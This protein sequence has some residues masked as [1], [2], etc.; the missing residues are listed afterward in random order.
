[1]IARA[2]CRRIW[3]IERKREIVAESLAGDMPASAVARK[4]DMSPGLLF[5]WRRQML[6][7][8]LVLRRR[9]RRA[10]HAWKSRRRTVGPAPARRE[11]DQTEFVTAA[12]R[13]PR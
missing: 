8:A 2:E 9:R 4:H 6:A 1:M 7:G 13:R 3:S 5:T 11:R 12:R 10:A